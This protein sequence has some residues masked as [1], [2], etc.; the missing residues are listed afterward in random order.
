MAGASGSPGRAGVGV[1][2]APLW[3]PLRHV[4]EL[5]ERKDIEDIRREEI[6]SFLFRVVEFMQNKTEW[7]GTAAELL[8]FDQNSFFCM[9]LT[10]IR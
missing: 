6:P 9:I 1:S 3:R 5:V 7:I 10:L 8:T 4:W 2:L